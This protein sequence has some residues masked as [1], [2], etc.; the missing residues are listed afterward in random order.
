MSEALSSVPRAVPGRGSCKWLP[1][2]LRWW[3]VA[4]CTF[5]GRFP[6]CKCS[7]W[8]IMLMTVEHVRFLAKAVT[9]FDK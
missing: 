1:E 2:G 4:L 6:A 5:F 8:L 9:V 7:G 3:V